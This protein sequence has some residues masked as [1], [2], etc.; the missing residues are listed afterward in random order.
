MHLAATA[1][2][3]CTSPAPPTMP[4]RVT[5]PTAWRFKGDDGE[6][7]HQ[8]GDRVTST[9]TSTST[10]NPLDDGQVGRERAEAVRLARA[11]EVRRQ[12]VEALVDGAAGRSGEFEG[13]KSLPG[14]HSSSFSSTFPASGL[15]FHVD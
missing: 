7:D 14:V 8:V 3:L 1:S 5:S 2:L 6:L 11:E 12:H 13:S 15:S 9:S 4:P 10:T